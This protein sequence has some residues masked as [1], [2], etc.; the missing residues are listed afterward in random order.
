MRLKSLL[1]ASF[2]DI[3][4]NALASD[5]LLCEVVVRNITV[6]LIS[7]DVSHT[8]HHGASALVLLASHGALLVFIRGASFL[9]HWPLFCC[10]A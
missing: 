2:G 7:N 3:F 6:H 8:C 5:K 9:L 10:T 4:L 1:R